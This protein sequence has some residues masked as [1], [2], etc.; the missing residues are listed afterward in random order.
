METDGNQQ[1]QDMFQILGKSY[2]L[3]WSQLYFTAVH[4]FDTE[5]VNIWPAVDVTM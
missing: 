1:L 3:L 5:E 2:R 4:V